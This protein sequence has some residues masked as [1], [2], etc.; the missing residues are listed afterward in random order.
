MDSPHRLLKAKKA[1][2]QNFLVNEGAIRTIVAA[3]LDSGAERLLEIGP[4]PGVL[5]ERL[6]ADGRPLWAV[7]LDP[8]AIELLRSRHLFPHF[9]L[10]LGDAVKLPLPEGPA[11]S[12]VGN[13]PYNAAT[14][15]L[16]RFL[17]EPIPWTRMVLMFQKE[18]GQKLMGRPG[19]KEYGPLSVLAQLCA[20]L[21]RLAALGPGSFR[22]SPKVDSIVLQFDPREDAPDLETRK[23]LLALLHRAFAHRR[24]T[25]S[26]T[27]GA[28]ALLAAGLDPSLRPEALAPDAWLHL[29]RQWPHGL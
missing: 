20:K 17:T 8:E 24:K 28:E 21:T 4:G 22:P 16:G 12:I 26:N 9:H 29:V 1:F 19:T 5:T 11:W 2:G 15:I 25:L 6:L 13:L 3:A 27:L 7:D 10:V 18:V 14:P 23:R